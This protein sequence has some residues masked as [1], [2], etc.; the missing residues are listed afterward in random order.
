MTT[1]NYAAAASDTVIVVVHDGTVLVA[2]A[3]ESP[4]IFPQLRA[5]IEAERPYDEIYAIATS[6]A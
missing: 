2:T 3:E 6:G 1:P 5:A 4:T